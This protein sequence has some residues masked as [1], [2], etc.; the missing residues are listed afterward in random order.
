VNKSIANG[1][2]TWELKALHPSSNLDIPHMASAANYVVSIEGRRVSGTPT[3]YYGLF[4]RRDPLSY[5][6]FEIRDD[7]SYRFGRAIDN[8][9]SNIASGTSSAIKADA[10]NRLTVLAQETHFT[11]FVN[12]QYVTSAD[13]GLNAGTAGPIVELLHVGDEG[14]FE[15]D[16][17]IVRAPLYRP[18]G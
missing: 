5:Y 15:F 14:V 10:A 8:Q 16:N 4:L 2:Y 7:G 1:K 6:V 9:I 18:V 17:F 12:D 13:A 3:N 11:L